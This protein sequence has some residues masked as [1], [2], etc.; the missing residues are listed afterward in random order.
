M[1]IVVEDGTGSNPVANSYND[2][3]SLRE[4]AGLRGVAVPAADADCEVLLIKAMDYLEG[5][6][7]RYKGRK[8]TTSQPLQ[9]PRAD[10]VGVDWPGAFSPNNE[11]PRELLYGQLALAIEAHS[12]D[13]Q[14]TRLPGDSGPLASK[15]TAG[16][17][18]AYHNTG[19]ALS[20]PAF[21]KADALIAPLLKN[22]GLS[23]VR[24]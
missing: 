2:V 5:L 6:R 3:P 8:T 18:R 7:G 16:L 14:P 23:L 17:K 9:W 4:Y 10:V 22:N 20:V 11:I 15:D 21:A 24:S 1:A 12:T 13:L 19:K